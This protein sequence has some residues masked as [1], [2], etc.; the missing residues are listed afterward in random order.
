MSSVPSRS[1]N[2][3]NLQRPHANKQSSAVAKDTGAAPSVDTL[4]GTFHAE[5]GLEL[6]E[7]ANDPSGP[8]S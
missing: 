2:R 3:C 8:W 1:T 5:S 4:S 7:S 6:R